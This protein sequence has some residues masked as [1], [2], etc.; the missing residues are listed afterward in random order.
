MS[1]APGRPA[2][3]SGR[4][5]SSEQ[6]SVNLVHAT[7]KFPGRWARDTHTCEPHGVAIRGPRAGILQYS[8]PPLRSRSAADRYAW[9]SLTVQSL[10]AQMRLASPVTRRR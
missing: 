2:R 1:S 9:R 6:A 10:K 3:S 8:W 4:I 7:R 5:A